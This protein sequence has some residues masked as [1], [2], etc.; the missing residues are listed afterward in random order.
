MI[1]MCHLFR[2]HTQNQ[3]PLFEAQNIIP[4]GDYGPLLLSVGF[5]NC[6]GCLC[7]CVC[8]WVGVQLWFVVRDIRA[9]GEAL[10][11]LQVQ[12]SKEAT[13]IISK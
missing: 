3:I 5:K 8:G 4:M 13:I 10:Y 11:T 7:V 2:S 1:V 9:A 12:P 6:N